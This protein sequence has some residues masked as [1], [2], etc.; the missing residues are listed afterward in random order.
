MASGVSRRILKAALP[1]Q[2]RARS[3]TRSVS[4]T[5]GVRVATDTSGATI[6]STTRATIS[7]AN[8]NATNNPNTL[9]HLSATHIGPLSLIFARRFDKNLAAFLVRLTERVGSTRLDKE[10]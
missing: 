4:G 7:T 1:N 5:T 9:C 8:I 3:A 2:R 6:L 10:G